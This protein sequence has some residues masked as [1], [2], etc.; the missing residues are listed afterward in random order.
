MRTSIVKVLKVMLK[1]KRHG[2]GQCIHF[3]VRCKALKTM[4]IIA[5]FSCQNEN[6]FYN[7]IKKIMNWETLLLRV[8]LLYPC[9]VHVPFL[10]QGMWVCETL[11]KRQLVQSHKPACA[12]NPNLELEKKCN[13]LPFFLD[14]KV[15]VHTFTHLPLMPLML[16]CFYQVNKVWLATISECSMEHIEGN[17]NWP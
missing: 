6:I 11:A 17:E 4:P 5:K 7:Y 13:L 8:I 3:Q 16:W 15:V 14:S 1:V 2:F 12:Q 10:L 9:V